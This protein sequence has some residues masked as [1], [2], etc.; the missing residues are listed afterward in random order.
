LKSRIG[1]EPPKSSTGRFCAQLP[2]FA[3]TV[4]I[5]TLYLSFIAN[6]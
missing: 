3:F 5:V 6:V 2:F 1:K 4:Y